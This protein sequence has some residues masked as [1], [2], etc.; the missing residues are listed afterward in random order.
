MSIIEILADKIKQHKDLINDFFIANFKQKTPL[1]YNSIDLRNSQFK[2]APVDSNIFP[3]GF[4]NLSQKSSVL[5]KQEIKKFLI[6]YRNLHFQEK[7]GPINILLIAEFHT[8]NQKYLANICNLKKLLQ[9]NDSDITTNICVATI[10]PEQESINSAE[11]YRT[12]LPEMQNLN[13]ELKDLTLLTK[14]YKK[15][16]TDSGFIADIAILNNDLTVAEDFIINNHNTHILPDPHFGWY[17]RSKFLHFT[18]YNKFASLLAKEINLDPWLITT[19]IDVVEDVDF[20]QKAQFNLLATKL[21]LQIKQ[22]EEK[23]RQYQIKQ[24]PY[25]YLKSDNGTY[26]MGIITANNAE[27]ILT[28]NKDKR[29]KMGVVKNSVASHRVLIQ[30][31]LPTADIYQQQT[32]EPLIYLINGTIV[33]NLMRVNTEKDNLSNLNSR[34]AFFVDLLAELEGSLTIDNKDLFEVYQLLA[35]IT[36]LANV[37]EPPHEAPPL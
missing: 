15:L 2:I 34:G 18:Q 33:A 4:N 5:A 37:N 32:A 8:R 14:D 20:K 7:N 13:P 6:N 17:R 35:K 16:I 9:F 23:Y 19:L 36:T 1:F 31:G 27:E 11:F 12:T 26:G 25:C 21:D 22:I 30:E 10:I 29:K 24:S 28:M 3:A